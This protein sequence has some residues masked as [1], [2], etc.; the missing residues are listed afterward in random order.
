MHFHYESVHDKV[1]LKQHFGI[2]MPSEQARRNVSPGYLSIF[3]RRHPMPTWA[4][5]RCLTAKRC[6]AALA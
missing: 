6:W 2:N 1:R 3:I 4:M 5:T